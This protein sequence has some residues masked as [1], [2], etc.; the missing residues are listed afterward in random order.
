MWNYKLN[1]LNFFLKQSKL[2]QQRRSALKLKYIKSNVVI[3]GLK[4][5]RKRVR[6]AVV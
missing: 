1:I 6:K 5:L 3:K 4:S 2:Q